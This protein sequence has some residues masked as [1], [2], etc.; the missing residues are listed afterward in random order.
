M[1]K[2]LDKLDGLASIGIV[3]SLLIFIFATLTSEVTGVKMDLLFLLAEIVCGITICFI[4]TCFISTIVE[5]V[6]DMK[7]ERK[8]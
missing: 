6:K 2:F 1:K 3:S 7:N 8:Q 5:L 4:V